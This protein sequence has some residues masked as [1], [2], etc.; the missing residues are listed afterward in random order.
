MQCFLC[1]GIHRQ[2][3]SLTV[4]IVSASLPVEPAADVLLAFAQYFHHCNKSWTSLHVWILLK[5]LQ[6]KGATLNGSA[7]LTQSAEADRKEVKSHLS[8]PWQEAKYVSSLYSQ[9]L[10]S[11]RWY[12]A[13]HVLQTETCRKHGPSR[14]CGE[15]STISEV[16]LGVQSWHDC[17]MSM[18]GRTA[19][20]QSNDLLLMLTTTALSYN[21]HAAFLRFAL[22][23]SAPEPKPGSLSRTKH[24]AVRSE[25]A[26]GMGIC[27][28]D[29]TAAQQRPQQTS[30]L[31]F[32]LE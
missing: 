16:Q 17:A 8:S 2:Y 10:A 13:A 3:F 5:T 14:S 23:L 6:K 9:P 4:Q 29:S 28:A 26:Y 18:K 27:P 21:S 20:G 22:W 25:W 30:Y 19:S 12:Q 24:T 32:L 11:K 31:Q 15:E 7:L 1:S